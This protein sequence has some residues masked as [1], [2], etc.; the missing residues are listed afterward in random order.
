[1]NYSYHN[2][3]NLGIEIKRIFI[4]LFHTIVNLLTTPIKFLFIRDLFGN[5]YLNL[6]CLRMDENTLMYYHYGHVK[7]DKS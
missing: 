2:I 6:G 3:G 4:S 7:I 1:M 5:A